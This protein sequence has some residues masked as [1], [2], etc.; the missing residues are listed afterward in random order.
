MRKFLITICLITTSLFALAG[1]QDEIVL[2]QARFHKGDAPHGWMKPDF[3]DSAWDV[4]AIPDKWHGE[5]L[6]AQYR[7]KFD[8]PE[9]FITNAPYKQYAICDLAYIDDCDE[10]YLNGVKI[11]KSGVMPHEGMGYSAWDSHR[12][13]QIDSGILKEGENIL[14][15]LVWN[16]RT[17]GGVYGGPFKVRM[18]T[19][20]DLLTF[21]FSGDGDATDCRMTVTTDVRV[22]G[23][24]VVESTKRFDKTVAISTKQPY[25]YD[26][27]YD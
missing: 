2:S 25:I 17:R 24:L 22:K 21:S 26:M 3:D 7:I 6:Y 1:P 5:G 9:G 11:G 13:Y 15:V 18:A 20:E 19:L 16:R 23:K 8:V 4:I 14:T 10:A 27:S 12:V